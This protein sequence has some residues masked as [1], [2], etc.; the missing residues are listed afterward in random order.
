MNIMFLEKSSQIQQGCSSPQAYFRF[1][2]YPSC[3]LTGIAM[4]LQTTGCCSGALGEFPAPLLPHTG[5][6]R[7]DPASGLHTRPNPG[8]PFILTTELCMSA[9]KEKPL[10]L[11]RDII[12]IQQ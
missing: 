5:E 6:R 10:L 3:N 7:E 2:L 9:G 8:S 12:I 4:S 1:N 11:H